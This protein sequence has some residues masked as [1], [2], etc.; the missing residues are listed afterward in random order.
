[1]PTVHFL[2]VCDGDCS[3]IQHYSGRVSV[4]DICNGHATERDVFAEL[5]EALRKEKPATGLPGNFGMKDHPTDPI[6]YMKK[7]GVE[8]VWRFI[9][10]HPEMDH[11]DGLKPL[12]DEIGVD[13]FWD[14]TVRRKEKPDFSQG[15]YSE[16]DWTKY[17]SI[18]QGKCPG[19][20]VVRPL[21]GGR[22]QFANQ[23]NPEERGDCLNIVA[24]NSELVKLAN[25]TDDPNDGS[26]VIV[27]RTCGGNI[28]F[29]G[30]SH[31]KTWEYILKNHE[32]M[33]KDCAVLIAPHHGRDSDRSYDFLD[34]VKPRLTLFGCAPSKDL[35]Y[36]AWHNRELP[37]ITNNQAGN[38]LLD[39]ADEG[40]HVYVENEVFAKK[41]PAFAKK[42]NLHDCFYIGRVP[43]PEVAPKVYA[44]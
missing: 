13:N 9:L 43:N 30:D 36:D 38:I 2:N 41:H 40:I 34:V 31:D 16:E 8:S 35:G 4:I 33:V 25:E 15:P 23:G 20:T 14:S 29:A 32:G 11:M 5:L 10:T 17:E 44:A 21:A 37:L 28:V 1:M 26:F 27:Y 7:I 42:T 19:M 18:I 3:I 6:A 24:P 12:C 22:F 39:A